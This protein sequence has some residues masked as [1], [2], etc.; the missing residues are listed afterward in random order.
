MSNWVRPIHF[1]GKIDH[2]LKNAIHFIVFWGIN[3]NTPIILLVFERH[4]LLGFVLEDKSHPTTIRPFYKNV[5]LYKIN[6]YYE[7]GLYNILEN[8]Q[9]ITVYLCIWIFEATKVLRAELAKKHIIKTNITSYLNILSLISFLQ[10]F[11]NITKYQVMTFKHI[12]PISIL[13]FSTRH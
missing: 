5:T 6:N 4:Q 13:L 1:S 8:K 9:C 10:F 2:L 12:V 11:S 3:A 7:D